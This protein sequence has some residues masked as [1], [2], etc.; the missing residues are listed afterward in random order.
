[1]DHALLSGPPGLGKTSLAMIMAKELG[2]ELH[3]VSGPAIEKKGDL[4]AVLTNLAPKDVLFIDASEMGFMKSR[5][6][7]DFTEEDIA[8]IR[9]TYLNWRNKT[10][11]S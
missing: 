3:V 6:H 1:M 7:R 2:T 8:K 5:V 9:D 11:T 10:V 4:A